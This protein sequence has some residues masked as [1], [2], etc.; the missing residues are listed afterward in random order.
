MEQVIDMA[1][2]NLLTTYRLTNIQFKPSHKLAAIKLLISIDKAA[3]IVEAKNLFDKIL[4]EGLEVNS[5]QLDK[6]SCYF[7]F[8]QK[9]IISARELIWREAQKEAKRISIEKMSI[10]D[11]WYENLTDTEKDYVNTLCSRYV[12]SAPQG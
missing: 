4:V 10:A 11:A 8:N 5:S 9:E 1:A 3:N 12:Y 7:T 2:Y 6:M